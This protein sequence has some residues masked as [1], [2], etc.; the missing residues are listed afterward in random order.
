MARTVR[1]LSDEAG[2]KKRKSVKSGSRRSRIEKADRSHIDA[3][4]KQFEQRCWDL[5]SRLGVL[6]EKL[7][8][9]DREIN[10]SMR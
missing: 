1:A 9:R 10:V 3:V 2:W 7:I 6:E 8:N 5:S 4:E